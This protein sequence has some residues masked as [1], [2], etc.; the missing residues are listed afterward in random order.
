MHVGGHGDAF[1]FPVTRLIPVD[2]HRWV[3]C[4]GLRFGY[5]G[6]DSL[7][8]WRPEGSSYATARALADSIHAARP[9]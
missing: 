2:E 9:E 5:R 3:V 7:T 1:V 6:A 8:S 4:N